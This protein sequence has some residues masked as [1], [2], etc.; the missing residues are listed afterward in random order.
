MKLNQTTLAAAA[1]AGLFAVGTAA[2]AA[3]SSA[4]TP[5]SITGE[6]E[7]CSG[8]DGCDGKD[9]KKEGT[10]ASVTAE[11]KSKCSG[12]DKCNGKDKEKEKCSGKEGCDGKDKKKEGSIL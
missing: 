9:K 5:T 10:T 4:A 8:K 1:L 6:K 12:K 7:K 2:N 11:E 3:Q